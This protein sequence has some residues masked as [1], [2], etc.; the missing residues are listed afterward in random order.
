V[1]DLAVLPGTMGSRQIE[2]T[3]RHLTCRTLTEREII[4]ASR[5]EGDLA[6]TTLLDRVGRGSPLTYGAGEVVFTADLSG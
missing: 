2:A 1:T 4:D 6:R 3:L 5:S